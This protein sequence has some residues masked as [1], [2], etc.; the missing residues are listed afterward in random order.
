GDSLREMVC[1]TGRFQPEPK[2]TGASNA[3]FR[4]A[5]AQRLQQHG[6]GLAPLGP[7]LE[8]RRQKSSHGRVEN[9]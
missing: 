8:Y 7:T 6:P 9:R 3:A 4:T 2:E 1:A 5:P